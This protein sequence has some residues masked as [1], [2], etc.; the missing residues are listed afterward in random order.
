[1]TD[2]AFASLAELARGLRDRRYSC[3]EL[4][5]VYLARIARFDEKANAYADLYAESARLA[6]QAADLQ[7][8]AGLPLSPLHGLP[9]AVKDLCEIE[10]QVTTAGSFAWKSR[11]STVSGAVAER[12][13]AAGMVL[14]GKTHMGEF[15]FGGWGIN[16]RMGTPRNPWDWSGRARA[17]GG[18]SSGSAV[19]VAAGLAPGAIGSDTGGSVRVPAAFNG[20]TGLKPTYGRI[21]VYGA[22]PLAASLDS[23]GTLT[24]TVEDAALLIDVLAG[25]D[26]RDPHSRPAPPGAPRA[27]ATDSIGHLRV[28]VMQPHQYPWPVTA[29]VQN[30]LDDAARVLDSLG[31]RVGPAEL[32]MTFAQMQPANAVI[33]EAEGYGVHA[34][35]IGDGNLPLGA[36]VRK[37]ISRGRSHSARDYLTALAHRQAAAR[38]FEEWMQSRD[39]LLTPTLPYPAPALA[40]IDEDTPSVGSF[41]RAVNYLGACA[42]SLP[43][44][45][46]NDGLPIGVQLISKP[47]N[48]SLLIQAGEAFQAVTDWHR[49]TPSGVR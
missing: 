3:V 12:L 25:F 29:E 28:A 41:T 4:T 45:F 37:R 39:L 13:R 21:S 6:A 46:S 47:W 36:W 38:S 11:R 42:V 33:V 5:E 2:I 24:R 49:R 14:L 17:P 34:E 18:S 30:A 40:E 9:I 32:P 20:L 31:C 16:P 15:A 35:Y 7:R 48:E 19:A 1:M 10:G 23:I 44:G 27:C 26:P 43:A 8:R 22:V